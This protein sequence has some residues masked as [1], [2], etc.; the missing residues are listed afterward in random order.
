M[1]LRGRC[2]A[3]K[4]A[5]CVAYKKGDI[6]NFFHDQA[7]NARYTLTSTFTHISCFLDDL[8]KDNNIPETLAAEAEGF[9][10]RSGPT[11]PYTHLVTTYDHKGEGCI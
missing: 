6:Q 10:V 7:S 9:L 8:A 1:H 11:C 3:Y 2:D 4:K 5:P